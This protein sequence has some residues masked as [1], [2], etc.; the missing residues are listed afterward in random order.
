MK[1]LEIEILLDLRLDSTRRRRT[2][3]TTP[4]ATS[5]AATP[6]VTA[7][8]IAAVCDGAVDDVVTLASI[9]KTGALQ[10]GF[11]NQEATRECFPRTSELMART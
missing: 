10:V 4:I 3:K 7:P 9:V 6:P 11:V 1:E 5:T 8:A 2:R